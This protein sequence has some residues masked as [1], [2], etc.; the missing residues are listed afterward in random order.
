MGSENNNLYNKI[1]MNNLES[2]HIKNMNDFS[3][4]IDT[5][6]SIYN[7]DKNNIIKKFDIQT[8]D[9]LISKIDVY[10]LNAKKYLINIKKEEILV[11]LI[12][13]HIDDLNNLKVALKNLKLKKYILV[14]N[15]IDKIIKSIKEL[16]NITLPEVPKTKFPTKKCKTLIN[17]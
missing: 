5:I 6:I 3:E 11:S 1:V 7:E 10:V 12:T 13:S 15:Y 16:D 9:Y 17:L 14:F 2:I 4:I 8:C